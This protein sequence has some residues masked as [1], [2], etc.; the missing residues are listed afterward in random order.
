[1]RDA[2]GAR[3]FHPDLAGV[4]KLQKHAQRIVLGARCDEA[5]MIDHRRH[6]QREQQRRQGLDRVG[7]DEDLHVPALHLAQ[8]RRG[9][10]ALAHLVQVSR[11]EGRDVDAQASHPLRM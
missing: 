7:W 2:V 4:Q 8:L 9:A 5:E 10:D 3:D 11:A 1:M 6:R